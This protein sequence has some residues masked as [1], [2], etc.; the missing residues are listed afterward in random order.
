MKNWNFMSYKL[1]FWPKSALLVAI[2]TSGAMA[3]TQSSFDEEVNAELDR[4]YQQKSSPANMS[5][6]QPT[7]QVNVK[8]SP[9]ASSSALNSAQTTSTL[10]QVQKQPTTVIESTPLVES[11]AERIRR[12]RQEVELATEQRIVERLEQSRIEDEKRRMENLFGD[13]MNQLQNSAPA[14]VA[15]TSV[16]P[17]QQVVVA[18]ANLGEATASSE[19]PRLSTY[20]G[21]LA[22]IPGYSDVSNIRSNYSAGFVVGREVS[23]SLNVEAGFQMA[24]YEISQRDG[25]Y[26]FGT[27]YPRLTNM[28]QY[29]FMVALKGVFMEDSMF[30]PNAGFSLAFSQRNY[31]DTR[32][33]IA[34]NVADSQSLDLGLNAGF[35]LD[36]TSKFALGMDIRYL[37]NLTTRSSTDNIFRPFGLQ[38]SNPLERLQT[39]QLLLAGKYFF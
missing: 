12:E 3:W 8:S 11:K 26:Y 20:L 37:W 31:R 24:N 17:V 38:N 7:V 32:L 34:N 35:D 36:L 25:A 4:M 13:R 1:S 29:Q 10:G 18:P 16:V 6:P 27:F 2:L 39:Y 23:T 15:P 22:G 5:A 21:L 19:E 9:Q 33:S 28:D 30:R 14:A